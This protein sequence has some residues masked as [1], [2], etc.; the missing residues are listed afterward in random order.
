M[1]ISDPLIIQAA[2]QEAQAVE[3]NEKS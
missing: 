2:T 1:I 3:V